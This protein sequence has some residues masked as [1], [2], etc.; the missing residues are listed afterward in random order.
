MALLVNSTKC[1]KI[2]TNPSQTH[3][4]ISQLI[5]WSQDSTDTKTRQRQHIEK[6][7][8]KRLQTNILY[9]YRC[10]IPQQNTSKLT[11]EPY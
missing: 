7:K 11:L 4:D 8:K 10:K 3:P 9:E 2:N 1:L 6:K 5:L